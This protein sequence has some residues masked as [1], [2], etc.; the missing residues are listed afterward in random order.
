MAR[1]VIDNQHEKNM[2][3]LWTPAIWTASLG[4]LCI[5]IGV[6][7]PEYFTY[8]TV[9]GAAILMFTIPVGV[10]CLARTIEYDRIRTEI[11]KGS[12]K[13]ITNP[14]IDKIIN[15][16]Y[17]TASRQYVCALALS[18]L[19]MGL[20]LNCS[21]AHVRAVHTTRKRRLTPPKM[22]SRN[23]WLAHLTPVNI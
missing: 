10:T 21:Y 3:R 18:T 22:F 14:R 20:D 11:L 1:K 5:T 9:M 17:E 4:A 13:S 16:F 12:A 6:F 15:K 2:L 7:L 19:E 23:W 8:S